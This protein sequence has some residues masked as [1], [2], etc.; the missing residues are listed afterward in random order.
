LSRVRIANFHAERDDPGDI[1][2]REGGLRSEREQSKKQLDDYVLISLREL[3]NLERRRFGTGHS[4]LDLFAR[5]DVSVVAKED[6]DLDYF[7]TGVKRG[8][9][10]SVF[11]SDEVKY[12]LAC[13]V[14]DE[15]VELLVGW[16]DS[17]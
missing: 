5:V 17:F 11:L 16:L 12:E 3:A 10:T 8:I 1:W 6:G 14:F 15:L 2:Q 13:E 4:S 9:T 7:V